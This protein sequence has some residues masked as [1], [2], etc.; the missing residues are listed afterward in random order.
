[1]QQSLVD[2][3]FIIVNQFQWDDD[4]IEGEVTFLAS[5]EYASDGDDDEVIACREKVEHY[6]KER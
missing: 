2:E 3:C 5:D 6:T 4:F 1:M